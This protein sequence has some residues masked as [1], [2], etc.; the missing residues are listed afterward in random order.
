VINVRLICRKCCSISVRRKR[1]S[2]AVD[3]SLSNNKK[4]E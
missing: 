1:I 3:D 4:W 2:S